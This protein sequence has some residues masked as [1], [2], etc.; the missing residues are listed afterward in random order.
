MRRRSTHRIFHI[1]GCHVGSFSIKCVPLHFDK[2]MSD[3]RGHPACD[4]IKFWKEL[5]VGGGRL[6]GSRMLLE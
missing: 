4:L 3:D 6:L 5:Q 2:L 1:F